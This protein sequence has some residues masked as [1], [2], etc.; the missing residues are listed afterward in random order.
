[1]YI[2]PLSNRA[3]FLK[4]YLTRGRWVCIG[5]VEWIESIHLG[6]VYAEE[7]GRDIK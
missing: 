6:G 3:V 5:E 2:V 7:E 1:M 4:I